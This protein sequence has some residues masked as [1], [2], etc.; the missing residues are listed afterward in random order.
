MLV[1]LALCAGCAGASPQATEPSPKRSSCLQGQP[2]ADATKVT[3]AELRANGRAYH[4]RRV[5]I[6]GLL[7]LK[8]EGTAVYDTP[9]RC[10]QLKEGQPTDSVWLTISPYVPYRDLCARRQAVVEGVY[11]ASERGMGFSI[12][13]LRDINLILSTG[14]IC[15]DVF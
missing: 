12:G 11:D 2:M 1:A 3:F 7:R 8:F 9:E 10:D 6:Q 14:P 5:R 4:G 15:E 13:G